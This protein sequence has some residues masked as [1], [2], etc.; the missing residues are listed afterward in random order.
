VHVC[1][2]IAIG[3]LFRTPL[4]EICER[5][6]PEGHPVTAPLLAGGP[7]ALTRRYEVRHDDAYADACHLCYRT[8]LALRDRFP[9]LLAPAQMYGPVA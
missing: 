4:R 8:R 9:E 5:Y 2:G 3:N 1:Q 7:A 6:D